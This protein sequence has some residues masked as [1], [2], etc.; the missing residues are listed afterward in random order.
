M[1][2]FNNKIKR[3]TGDTVRMK[4]LETIELRAVHIDRRLLNQHIALLGKEN[5]SK[6]T[7]RVYRNTGVESDWCIH[8]LHESDKPVRGGSVTAVRLKEALKE[9]GMINYSMWEEENSV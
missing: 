9:L 3:V 1:T 6:T 7:I 8:L 5:N 4:W 2:G